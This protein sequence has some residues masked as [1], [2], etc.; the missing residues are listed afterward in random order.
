MFTL[1]YGSWPSPVTTELMTASTVRL[2]APMLDGSDL[3]WIEAR[4]D[5]GGRCSLWRRAG[6][7]AVTELTPDPFSVRSRVYEYGGGEYAV[8]DGVVVFSSFA[9]GRLYRLA[10]GQ[11]PTAITPEGSS[12]YADLRVLPDR[13][14][15]LAVR[16]EHLGGE[17]VNTIVA[18]DLSGPNPEGGQVLCEGADFY[19]T[20]ELSGDGWLAWTQWQHP[21]MPWDATAIM[22]G[23]PGTDGV[24]DVR[25]VAGGPGESAVEPRWTPA[26][27]LIFVSDR[28]G[29]WNLYRW[30]TNGQS[31]PL[32][33]RAAEFAAPQWRLG[34]PPYAVLD[35]D[36]LV[37]TWTAGSDSGIGI[38][39]LGTE[40]L[41]PVGPPE[42]W[43][44][45]IRAGGG[46]VAAVLE[47][48]RRPPVL[49]VLD[50]ATGQWSEVRSASDVDLDPA[51]VSVAEEVTWD[52]D[53]GPVHGWFYPPAHASARAP[54][55][56]LPPL[57]TLS[58]G[59]PTDFSPPGFRLDIQYWT[60][61]GVAVLDVNYGGSSGYGRAYRERLAGRWGLVDVADCVAGAR[62]LADRGRVDGSRLAIRGGSAGGYTT[63]RALTTSTV[64]RAG[65]SLFGVADLERL[66]IDTHKFESRYL[67][68]LIGPYPEAAA[69]YRERSPLHHLDQL[70]APILLLQGADDKIVPPNQAE[71]MAAAARARGLPV[72]LVLFDHEGHGFRR[73]ESIRA[74]YQAELAFLGRVFGFSPA[75]DL[76]PLVIDNL[77]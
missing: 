9:D 66:A 36:R 75:D 6:D 57:V 65:I 56:S 77:P 48:R 3:Y 12:R 63:L 30:T 33:P 4:P 38:L 76:P 42:T 39:T 8:R 68:G 44:S 28:S 15:V 32:H 25:Q 51:S 64:F 49:A 61:R 27:A 7:G 50:V 41:A 47:S 70:N 37:C 19:A 20:P 67:D 46:L 18:L 2:I 54:A 71:A 40:T 74:A 1:P 73:A 11:A 31:Q 52:S 69:V 34:Q 29:W 55:G 35:D 45:G 53:L 62:A 10:D 5:Q 14:L 13:D 16:E 22:I 60:S 72:A 26:G 24:A 58:H 21:D 23:R 17:P 59:G 43:T